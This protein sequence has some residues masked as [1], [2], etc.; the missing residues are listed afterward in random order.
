[1]YAVYAIGSQVEPDAFGAP[2]L[3]SLPAA[4]A[5]FAAAPAWVRMNRIFYD[6]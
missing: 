3:E 4:D 5:L 2:L 1:M 6:G